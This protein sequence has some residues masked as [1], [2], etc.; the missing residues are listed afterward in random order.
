[1]C[2][3]RP[4]GGVG[5][6]DRLRALGQIVDGGDDP[7]KAFDKMVRPCVFMRALVLLPMS[8]AH[9]LH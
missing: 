4:R 3:S 5:A 8:R 1:M 6:Q 9:R 2:S 7:F